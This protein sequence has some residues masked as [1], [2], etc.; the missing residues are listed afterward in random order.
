[1]N[2]K[3][4]RLNKNIKKENFKKDLINLIQTNHQSNMNSHHSPITPLKTT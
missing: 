4:I 3:G 2:L 1:M